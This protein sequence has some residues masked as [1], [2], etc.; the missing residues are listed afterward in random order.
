MGVIQTIMSFVLC[1]AISA[2]VL[3]HM[4]DGNESEVVE[5]E[6]VDAVID[7]DKVDYAE[8]IARIER[9]NATAQKLKK[10]QYLKTDIRGLYD[11]KNNKKS[12]TCS[13]SSGLDNA[14]YS[15]WT[16]G[17]DTNAEHLMKMAEE[18]RA[19]IR[20]SLLEQV[21]QLSSVLRYTN[22]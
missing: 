10:V 9:M 20:T 22:A 4:A 15:F 16:D 8:L 7:P 11:L 14:E 17:S 2:G 5:A 13:W 6:V 19:Y 18:E 12:F 21:Q 1:G 3:K